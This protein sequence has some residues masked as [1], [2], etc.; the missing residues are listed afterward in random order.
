MLYYIEKHGNNKVK[1]IDIMS[2]PILS[3]VCPSVDFNMSYYNIFFKVVEQVEKEIDCKVRE[4]K[5]KKLFRANMHW[6]VMAEALVVPFIMDDSEG[7]KE[8]DLK[9]IRKVKEFAKGVL[10]RLPDATSLNLNYKEG[11]METFYNL[12]SNHDLLCEDEDIKRINCVVSERISMRQSLPQ[13]HV[14]LYIKHENMKVTKSDFYQKVEDALDNNIVDQGTKEILF[15]VSGKWSLDETDKKNI[16]FALNYVEVVLEWIEDFKKPDTTNGHYIAWFIL[17][18]QEIIY[19]KENKESFENLVWG[20]KNKKKS[21]LAILKAPEQ[22]DE[23]FKRVWVKKMER[24]S[25]INAGRLEIAIEIGALEN[26]L[27][28]IKKKIFAYQNLEDLIIVNDFI[29]E[30]FLYRKTTT[31]QALKAATDFYDLVSK[32]TGYKTVSL[33]GLG[34]YNMFKLFFIDYENYTYNLENIAFGISEII[35]KFSCEN[36]I[37]MVKVIKYHFCLPLCED[38]DRQFALFFEVDREKKQVIYLKFK[39]YMEEELRDK[40]CNLGLKNLVY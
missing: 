20:A 7:A 8:R 12:L 32:I 19:A 25:L 37:C 26:T 15:L 40:L 3:N 33:D 9:E 34:V 24:N 28:E 18:M 14:E 11:L 10:A 23:F 17:A 5:K 31:Q 36:K 2:N 21:L 35:N 1:I 27:Y 30:L 22:A 38:M 29:L 16:K 6:N 39:K 13:E 4:E